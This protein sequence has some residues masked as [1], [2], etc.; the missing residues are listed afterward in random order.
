MQGKYIELCFE[1]VDGMKIPLDKVDVIASEIVE[2]ITSRHQQPD[3]V[4]KCKQCK[5]FIIRIDK[6]WLKEPYID[7]EYVG[8][9]DS[10]RSRKERLELCDI[11]GFEYGEDDKGDGEIYLMWSGDNEYTNESQKISY[12]KNSNMI[13]EICTEEYKDRFAELKKVWGD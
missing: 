5:A 11:V 1:N 10:T 9:S 3:L 6:E 8:H 2:Y 4:S 7:F 13:I 12:D